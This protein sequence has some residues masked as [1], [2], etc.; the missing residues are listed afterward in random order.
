MKEYSLFDHFNRYLEDAHETKMDVFVAAGEFVNQTYLEDLVLSHDG[1]KVTNFEMIS[2]LT[3]V[4]EFHDYMFHACGNVSMEI[5]INHKFIRD[6]CAEVL[7]SWSSE[8]K[9][10]S[11]NK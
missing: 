8:L 7:W 6:F 5:K 11:S 1:Q 4:K 3:K 10:S 9:S 2:L